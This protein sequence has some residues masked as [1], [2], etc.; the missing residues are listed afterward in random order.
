MV[1]YLYHENDTHSVSLS[2][3]AAGGGGGGG[4]VFR[5]CLHRTYRIVKRS[6]AGSVQDRASVQ[7]R[8]T[9]FETIFAS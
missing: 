6:V 4:E 7:T 3:A 9:T 8:K 2:A 5:L 1:K